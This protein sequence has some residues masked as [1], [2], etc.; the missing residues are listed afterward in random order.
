MS[1]PPERSSTAVAIRA[2]MT[3]W[4]NEDGVTSGPKRTRDV[5]AASHVS[6]VH[7]SSESRSGGAAFVKWSD[8]NNP[9]NPSAS[10]AWAIRRHRG[11]V[12]PF[13]PSTMIETSMRPGI[14]CPEVLED[15]HEPRIDEDAGPQPPEEIPGHAAV[16]EVAQQQQEAYHGED[17]APRRIPAA[18]R[19]YLPRTSNPPTPSSARISIRTAAPSHAAFTCSSSLRGVKPGSVSR[20]ATPLRA[21]TRTPTASGTVTTIRPTPPLIS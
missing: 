2:V 5:L 9:A 11:Q 12:R 21:R 4:R 6:D 10:T 20:L 8:R 1:R 18:H 19:R 14:L 3:G 16:A 15:A 13:W 7:S 17:H